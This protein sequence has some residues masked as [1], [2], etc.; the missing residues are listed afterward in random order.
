VAAQVAAQRL[1]EEAQ[2]EARK[3]KFA[4]YMPPEVTAPSACNF[5]TQTERETKASLLQMQL[6]DSK[7][8]GKKGKPVAAVCG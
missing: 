6:F 1:Q 2:Q 3:G 5:Y 4:L 7:L 8:I